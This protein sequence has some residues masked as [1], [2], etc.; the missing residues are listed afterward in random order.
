[1]ASYWT[2]LYRIESYSRQGKGKGRGKGRLIRC[3]QISTERGEKR[4]ESADR[5]REKHRRDE[6][7]CKLRGRGG[8][9]R[10]KRSKKK[11]EEVRSNGRGGRG[12][13]GGRKRVPLA[14]GSL[15]CE[16]LVES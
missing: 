15:D 3:C 11:N 14:G 8:R 1:M 6:L 13:G 9:E 5:S 7:S 16:L 2:V 4:R 10:A 12:G